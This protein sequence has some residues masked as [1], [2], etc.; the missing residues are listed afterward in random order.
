MGKKV[1]GLIK[2]ILLKKKNST[3]QE[4]IGLKL[5]RKFLKVNFKEII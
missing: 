3:P 4:V 2:M 5:I 1:L